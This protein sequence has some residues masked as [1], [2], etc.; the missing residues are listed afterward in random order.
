MSVTV[1]ESIALELTSRLEA[2]IGDS[3]Y[4]TSVREV[5]RPR[6]LNDYTP[7]D[8]QIVVTQG[9]SEVVDE[10]SYP[11]NPPAI[12]RRQTFN[13][14]CH[15]INDERSRT[16][17]DEITN[18]FAADV[19]KAVCVPVSTWYQFGGYAI[20][21]DFESFELISGDGGLDGVNVP[22]SILYRTDENNP[23]NVRA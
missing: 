3:T 20:N 21:A 5:I 11:G 2:M 4:D 19:I 8:G 1:I 16:T 23:Y 22:V 18:T 12:A 9:S 17:I 10:L 13:I 14:R 6:R 7:A 15:V